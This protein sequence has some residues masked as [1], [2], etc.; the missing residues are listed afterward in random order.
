MQLKFAGVAL[1]F[2]ASF[3]LAA[4]NDEAPS[5]PPVDTPRQ[6]EIEFDFDSKTK[7]KIVTVPPTFTTQP[8]HRRPATTTRAPATT[9]RRT[10]S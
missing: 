6:L 1:T 5:A 7:T 3:T 9:T 2:I 8:P 10:T 4:C